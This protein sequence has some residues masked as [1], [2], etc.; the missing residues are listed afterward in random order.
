GETAE[1]E[2]LIR[3]WNRLEST[4]WPERVHNRDWSCQILGMAGAAGSAVECIRTGLEQ[5]SRVMPYLEP[6]LPYY[7]PIRGDPAFVALQDELR[8]GEQASSGTVERPQ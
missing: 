5:P 2:R 4:D 6:L 3:R 1:T 7:D 8:A